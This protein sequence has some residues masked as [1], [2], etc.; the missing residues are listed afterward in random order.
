VRLPG[1]PTLQVQALAVVSP[2]RY[3]KTISDLISQDEGERRKWEK[4]GV[5]GKIFRVGEKGGFYPH[6]ILEQGLSRILKGTD[7]MED[8][9]WKQVM[10]LVGAVG[11]ML[12]VDMTYLGVWRTMFP[13]SPGWPGTEQLQ[14]GFKRRVMLR[15]AFSILDGKEWT[16]A[17]CEKYVGREMQVA[18]VGAFFGL[19][20]QVREKNYERMKE[21]LRRR[22][23]LSFAEKQEFDEARPEVSLYLRA[24]TIKQR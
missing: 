3:M 7:L 10:P 22:R 8:R 12:K 1:M 23:E 16:V 6:V 18:G 17:Q 9:S 20:P 19:Y 13:D 4:A 5:F 11:K 2:A 24:W 15:H 14:R 21:L